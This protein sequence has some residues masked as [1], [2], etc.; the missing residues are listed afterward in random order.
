MLTDNFITL[1]FV[2]KPRA[3]NLNRKRAAV[4]SAGLR[5]VFPYRWKDNTDHIPLSS[6]A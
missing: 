2:F 3:L 5:L 4:P 6:A 1:G